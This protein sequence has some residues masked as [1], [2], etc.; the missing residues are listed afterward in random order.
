MVYSTC[1]NSKTKIVFKIKEEKCDTL[2]S[3]KTVV[4]EIFL[5]VIPNCQCNQCFE[6]FLQICLFNM[7][8]IQIFSHNFQKQQKKQRFN[9]II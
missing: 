8:I 6:L 4:L 2:K 9:F 5:P 7:M 1:R 3:I